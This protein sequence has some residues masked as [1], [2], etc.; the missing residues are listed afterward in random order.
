MRAL[1]RRCLTMLCDVTEADQVQ[2]VVDRTVQEFGHVD[3][4][5]NNAAFRRGE[6]RVPVVEMEDDI[7]R[8]V[9]DIK[10]FGSFLFSKAVGKELIRRNEGGSIINMSSIAG[11]RGSAAVSAYNASNFA[12]H[13]F[14]QAMALEL[15]PYKVTVNAVCPGPVDTSRMD[16]ARAE[17]S[18]EVTLARNPLRRVATDEDIG[19]VVTWLCMPAASLIT[20]QHINVNGGMVMD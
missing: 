15:A 9:M 17:T 4:L 10:V 3:I 1:G 16:G 14:T 8:Q 7:F 20:G 5:V 11:R 6:D 12:I 2:A 13:G 19:E 18:I